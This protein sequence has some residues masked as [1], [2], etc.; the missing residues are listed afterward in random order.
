[1]RDESADPSASMRPLDDREIQGWQRPGVALLVWLWRLVASA[2]VAAPI[3][4]A[5]SATGV[6]EFP[7]GDAVLFEPGGVMAVEAARVGWPGLKAAAGVSTLLL[8]V[9]CVMSVVPLSAW[10]VALCH[11]G[12]LR[13][14][15][16]LGAAMD[17]VPGLVFITGVGWMLRGMM[18]VIAAVVL[19]AF[20]DDA[21]WAL[22]ALAGVT[23]VLLGTIAAFEALA[24]AA[25]VR[26][27]HGPFRAIGRG[28]RAGF[29]RL[30]TTFLAYTIPAVASI[31]VVAGAAGTT[32][33]YNVAGPGGGR[34][35][36]AFVLHQ[37]AV[38]LLIALRGWWLSAALRLVGKPVL[39]GAYDASGAPGAE[40]R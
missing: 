26:R 13:L 2:L 14:A 12:R 10:L 36:G 5:I 9:A 22:G 40:R 6:G 24:Q 27:R 11:G 34:V 33:Y 16:W 30:G 39:A 37:L 4:A 31:A 15:G 8:L 18:L 29:R 7:G 28:L 19:N 25:Y 20:D 35:F 21:R 32:Q 23:I 1:M 38:L 17:R 3:T